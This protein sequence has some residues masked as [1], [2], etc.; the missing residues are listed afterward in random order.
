MRHGKK[1][2]SIYGGDIEF[3]T[4][5]IDDLIR[6][7]ENLA[8]R[9]TCDEIFTNVVKAGANVMAD[10][11]RAEIG[12]LKT[13]KPKKGASD[14]HRGKRYC[15]EN[16][17]RG[18][19]E[20][21][22]WAPVKSFNGIYNSNIGFDGYN[23]YIKSEDARHPNALIANVIECGSGYQI[24]QPFISRTRRAGKTKAIDKM[25]EMLDEEIQQRTY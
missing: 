14:Y 6:M 17:K 21:M 11:M 15:T 24:A 7:L 10:T 3:S 18:L 2:K 12:K 9:A 16:E 19:L 8:D 1:D 22:G 5:G 13:K 25:S 23:P 20:S 4:R